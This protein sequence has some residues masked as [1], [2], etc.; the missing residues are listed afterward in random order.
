MISATRLFVGNLPENTEDKDVFS[1][2]SV[3]GEIT[4]V[5]LK[6]KNG[7]GNENKKFAF[8]SLSA[9]NVDV[10]SCKYIRSYN[11]FHKSNNTLIPSFC[12]F[13]NN[14]S[15]LMFRSLIMWSL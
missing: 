1:A 3:F 7:A 9:P 10:E 11:Y 4:N 13:I 15:I 12:N 5:D 14:K 8:V 6:V 2:F